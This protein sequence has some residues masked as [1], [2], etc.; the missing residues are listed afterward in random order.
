MKTSIK[1]EVIG[2]AVVRR[3]PC[4]HDSQEQ[5]SL[6]LLYCGDGTPWWTCTA[7]LDLV[8]P[9]DFEAEPGDFINLTIEKTSE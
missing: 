2:R 4:G 1:Y 7:G 9:A 3:R 8:V 6:K 5:H